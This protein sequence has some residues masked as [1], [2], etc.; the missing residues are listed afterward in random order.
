MFSDKRM[1]SYP[2]SSKR[3][4]PEEDLTC[5]ICYDIFKDPVILLCS[6]SICKDCLEQ[7]WRRK[8][9]KQC[10]VCRK[11]SS[12]ESPVLNLSL[13]NLCE[14]FLKEKNQRDAGMLCSLHEE[15]LKLFCQEDKQPVCLVCQT[16][17]KHAGHEFLPIDEAAQDYKEQ[18]KAV[19]LPLQEK[20]KKYEEVKKTCDQTAN[21]IKAQAQQSEKQIKAE[22]E[23]LHQ[24]LKDQ[25]ETRIRTLKHEEEQ[26]SLVMKEKID[27]MSKAISILS[28][29]ITAI[30]KQMVA[31]DGIFLQNF[32]ATIKSSQCML[33]NSES[34]SLSGALI[35]VPKHLGNLKF[36]VR[37]SMDQYIPVILDPNTAHSSLI[38]SEDLTSLRRSHD[39]QALPNNPERCCLWECVLG[40]EG[41][42]SGSHSWDVEVVD[43]RDWDVGVTTESNWKRFSW[44]EVWRVGYREC[45]LHYPGPVHVIEQKLHTLRVH[46][47]LDRGQ[48]SF[49]DALQDTHVHTF[50]H[51]FTEKAFPFFY[52]LDNHTIRILPLNNSY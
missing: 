51:T 12:V 36:R 27:E 30:E 24:F 34:V 40:S 35:D 16:S 47:D 6:H 8:K 7:F 22:F 5:P 44:K 14:V 1:A 52:L 25:E 28:D 45:G 15:R 50:E 20:L 32:K 21:H 37:E 41:Y 18:L 23:G 4:L 33:Q 49:F 19:L 11:R 13:R 10:P 43:S 9:A 39:A 17:R 46:L 26:K 2:R 3:S 42:S 38:I 31:E 29:K 48:L